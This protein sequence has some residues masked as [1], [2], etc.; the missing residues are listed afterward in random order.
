MVSHISSFDV[1]NSFPLK[2]PPFRYIRSA[3]KENQWLKKIY[4]IIQRTPSKV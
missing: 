2:M 3:E 1:D 4:S